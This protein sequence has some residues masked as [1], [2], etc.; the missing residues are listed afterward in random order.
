MKQKIVPILTMFI[1]LFTLS[2]C[3][4]NSAKDEAL[5]QN[6]PAVETPT[7][8]SLVDLNS[9]D[10]A[11]VKEKLISF[12]TAYSVSA[13][14]QTYSLTGDFIH[15]YGDTL[16]LK[17]S[18]GTEILSERQHRRYG[19]KLNRMASIRDANGNITGYIGEDNS[20]DWLSLVTIFHIYDYQGNEIA[21]VKENWSIIK[22]FTVTD[23]L[24][25]EAYRINKKALSL[26]NEYTITKVSESKIPMSS[27]ILVTA[28]S[29]AISQS[30]S[31]K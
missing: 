13:N 27:M 18:S 4:M 11:V 28:I 9:A 8:Q 6:E 21:K 5:N 3:V 2:G 23:N 12:N 17:D 30:E 14:N 19:F 16:T 29:D 31:N 1:A 7:N 25:N 10:K 22:S 15:F 24:G 20:Q 26:Q